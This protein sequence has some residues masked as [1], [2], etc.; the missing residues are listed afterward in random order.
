MSTPINAQ[1]LK[2]RIDVHLE[3]LM[4][5]TDQ[6]RKSKGMQRYLEFMARFHNYSFYNTLLIM[7]SKPDATQVAGFQTWKK[8]GR[9]VKPGQRGIPIFAPLVHREDP[10]DENSPKVLNGFKVVY[11]FDLSQTEGDPL[12]IVPQWIS[13]E[14]NP[15]LKEKLLDFARSKSIAV[16]FKEL[17]GE[18]Q[19]L[20]KGGS[21][22]ISPQAGTKTIIHEIAHE[23]MHRS[24]EATSD[25]S[26]REMEAEAVGYVVSKYFNIQCLNSPN[27]IS[28]TGSDRDDIA[29][30]ISKISSVSREIINALF[31]VGLQ[32]DDWSVNN[33]LS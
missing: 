19:G 26:L 16:S 24:E 11:V 28:L 6:A 21:I 20:S 8:L 23:M 3:D 9:W 5:E 33:C 22:E 17:P 12:P 15:E 10:L 25:P 13:P 31:I 32:P 4:S 18:I 7:L 27:Y 14:Q 29:C 30:A 1:E 2:R